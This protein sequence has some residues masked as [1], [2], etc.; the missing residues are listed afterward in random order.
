LEPTPYG[1]LPI[2][3]MAPGVHLV[4]AVLAGVN[5]NF[6]ITNTGTNLTITQEDARAYYTGAV[7]VGTVTATSHNA[8]VTLS[9]TIKDITS[10]TPLSDTY[11]GDIR[12]ARVTF[13]NRDNNT[14]IASNIPVGLVSLA[15]TK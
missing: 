1:T 13:I 11:P 2:G 8:I 12:N 9:A 15:D 3:Q 10:V 7:Y 4:T 5:S 6:T 14:I